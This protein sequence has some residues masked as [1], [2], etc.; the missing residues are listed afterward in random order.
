MATHNPDAGDNITPISSTW[1][2]DEHYVLG[3]ARW[4]HGAHNLERTGECVINFPDHAQW[5]QV[6]RLADT[7]GS[8]TIPEP[9]RGRYRH[10]PDKW[11]LGGF[12]STPSQLVTPARIA[13]CPVQIEATLRNV[14]ALTDD[15]AAY[16]VRVERVHVHASLQVPGTN[17]VETAAWHPL[18]YTFRHY[19][20]QGTHLGRTFKAER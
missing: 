19:F 17:Y 9:K 1:A 16:H 13:E 2:L 8:R 11:A 6:E 15:L 7:T 5:R 3:M 10:V 20:A 12:T 14:M 18:Y 4:N